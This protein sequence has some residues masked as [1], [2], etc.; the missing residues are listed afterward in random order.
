MPELNQTQAEDVLMYHKYL[1]YGGFEPLISDFDYD[2]LEQKFKEKF[3][4][5]KLINDSVE[6]PRELWAKYENRRL[7]ALA[8]KI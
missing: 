2:K 8:R 3:P 7:R 5:S 6:C 1:Y 4:N